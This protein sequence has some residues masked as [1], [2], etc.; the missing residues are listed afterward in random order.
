MWNCSYSNDSFGPYAEDIDGATSQ[1][2]LAA[3][4]F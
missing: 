3:G 4:L 1:V 2:L